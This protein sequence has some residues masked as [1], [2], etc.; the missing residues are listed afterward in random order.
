MK[1]CT[2]CDF[3]FLINNLKHIDM[4]L[5]RFDF[6][7]LRKMEF[8]D[9]AKG[10]I[11]ISE[12]YDVTA[13]HLVGYQQS[14]L[15]YQPQVDELIVRYGPHPLTPELSMLWNQMNALTVA[16]NRTISAVEKAKLASLAEE[17][18]LVLPF[19]KRIFG[20]LR[21]ENRKATNEKMSQFNARLVSDEAFAAAA[22]KLG[23]GLLFGELMVVWQEFV[24]LTKERVVEVAER[25]LMHTA[26]LIT[27]INKGIRNFLKGIE[28][29][30]WQYGDEDYK[31]LVNE[32]NVFMGVYANLVKSRATQNKNKENVSTSEKSDIKETVAMSA[33][34]SA[35]ATA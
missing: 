28:L 2:E 22:N 14:L 20:K 33:N 30:M 3:K 1:F 9:F 6:Q 26:E 12:K 10:I 18:R 34:N 27:S 4:H 13:L 29:A 17:R 32:L 24:K 11:D 21:L 31:P 8:A 5:L 7:K 15:K 35:T 23:F 25:P 19:L 16:I